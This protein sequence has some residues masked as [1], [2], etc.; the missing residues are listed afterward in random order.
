MS[1]SRPLPCPMA[2]TA[3]LAL[4]LAPAF[5]AHA[6]PKTF[7]IGT[8]AVNAVWIESGDI[9]GDGLADVVTAN[10]GSNN[11]S[12][13]LND[14]RGGFLPAIV[15]TA[16]GSQPKSVA[17]GDF[18]G[19][20]KLDAVTANFGSGSMSVLFGN[21]DGTF[22]P[23]VE[24]P[25]GIQT[26]SV[27]VGD[28]DNDGRPD[29]MIASV[30]SENYNAYLSNGD[31]TFTGPIIFTFYNGYA[32][33]TQIKLGDMDGDG[34]LDV[35]GIYGYGQGFQV[36]R[37]KGDGSFSQWDKWWS[38]GAIAYPEGLALAKFPGRRVPDIVLGMTQDNVIGVSRNLG[39][40]VFSHAVTSPAPSATVLL[41][42]DDVDGDGL[43]DAIT[44]GVSKQSLEVAFGQG[45]GTFA[46]PIDAPTGHPAAAVVARL[47]RG[48]QKSIV[49]ATSD[50]V[51]IL[52]LR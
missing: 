17:L 7:P 42:V 13:L 48:K 33:M 52:R 12:V 10:Q 35:V 3:T 5:A 49:Y 41:A 2:I 22:R 8:G 26:Q 31:G 40:G 29:I 9:N 15:S 27:C 34:I 11:L 23:A 20:G 46:S 18:D 19:D 1:G 21:G 38:Y 44:T 50:A 51:G 6:A 24:F 30:Q 32:G 47:G 45:D 16:T 25:V 36:W 4:A 39:Q 28:L 43:A 37:G 14:G